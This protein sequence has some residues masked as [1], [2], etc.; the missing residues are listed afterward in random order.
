[1]TEEKK[2]T[3]TGKG[4]KIVYVALFFSL[5]SSVVSVASLIKSHPRTELDF[6]YL[7]AIVGLLSLVTAIIIGFQ[8][9]NAMEFN[10]TIKSLRRDMRIQMDEIS[11]KEESIIKQSE[12]IVK[13][14][15]DYAK[16]LASILD[17]KIF[18]SFLKY[19]GLDGTAFNHY[20]EAY[21]LAYK[22]K[23]KD[24]T[25]ELSLKIQLLNMGPDFDPNPM[26][27]FR[28]FNGP[29]KADAKLLEAL[30]P[31]YEREFKKAKSG[32]K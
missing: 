27:L 20:A 2:T 7:G 15:K 9:Y 28:F 24:L 13:E 12:S 8:I 22:I 1:M 10:N 17:E 3:E 18:G 14:A 23:D 25:D 6:D 30:R 26:L 32:V 21:F 4:G 31:V 16:A 11:S 29:L 19:H 5:L